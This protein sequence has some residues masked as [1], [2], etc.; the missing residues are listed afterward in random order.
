MKTGVRPKLTEGV[1]DPVPCL[2]L[3]PSVYLL[4]GVYLPPS[5]QLPPNVYLPPSGRMF[6]IIPVSFRV[7]HP[8][9]KGLISSQSVTCPGVQD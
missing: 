3:S 7:C 6:S 8:V 2:Y 4:R 5:M 9:C 1:P